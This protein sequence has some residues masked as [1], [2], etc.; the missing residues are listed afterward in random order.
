MEKKTLNFDSPRIVREIM[1]REKG[2]SAVLEE[3]FGVRV[4]A[5][6]NFIRLS[7]SGEKVRTVGRLLRQLEKLLLSG[8]SIDTPEYHRIMKQADR[9][10]VDSLGR[11]F[12]DRIEL[13]S[14]RRY[15]RP[16]TP[17][18]QKYVEAI[19]RHEV[20]IA[21]GPAG[22]GKTYLA[23]AM[24]VS[25]LLK[26]ESRRMIL[27]RPAREAGERLGFLPGGLQEKIYPYLRPLYDALYDM[28]E[29][30]RI[31]KYEE[32]GV[33]EVAPLAFM[34]GRTFNNS[35][36]ILDEAQNT[37]PEQMKMFL[38]RL[39]FNSRMV[40]TGDITQVDLPAGKTSGLVRVQSIL[41]SVPGVGFSYFDRKDV[42]RHRIVQ[43]IVQAYEK[44]E[45]R[46]GK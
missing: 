43:K 26:G 16:Q 1:A 17:N 24:A 7:G 10:G 33:I 2:N 36:I 14:R 38:T 34:R 20:V 21:I 25:S 40:V 11:F 22:T 46:P 42:V 23:M 9:E 44:A 19:R 8:A 3:V 4:V 29:G 32:Q 37:T 18:Q 31:R 45:E 28:L 13:S 6:D 12:S 39:G 30:P 15:V 35:F 5:R 27:T 41:K